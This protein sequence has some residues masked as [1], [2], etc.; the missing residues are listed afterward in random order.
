GSHMT[1][2]TIFEASKKVT[3]SLSNLISLIGT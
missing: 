1:R 2:E 3:N